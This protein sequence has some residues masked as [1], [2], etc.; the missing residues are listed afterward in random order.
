[1]A[2]AAGES[3]CKWQRSGAVRCGAGGCVWSGASFQ[4]RQWNSLAFP[5]EDRGRISV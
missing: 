4:L 2:T 3:E 5:L 1:M